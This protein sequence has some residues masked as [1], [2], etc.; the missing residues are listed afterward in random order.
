[1]I[2][3]NQAQRG[4]TL[5]ELLFVLVI[6]ATV[7]A[8]GVSSWA[9]LADKNRNLG[10]KDGFVKVLV[11]ARSY[12]LANMANVDLCGESGG[13]GEG[14]LVRDVKKNA[15]LYRET[16]YKEVHPVGP[17]QSRLNSGCVR[18]LSNGSIADVPAPQG[19]FYLSGFYGGKSE[20]EALWRVSF[21]PTGWFCEE[22]D[23]TKAQC[24]KDQ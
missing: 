14:Y 19:G 17:W 2:R 18:F 4:V 23:P 7:I 3:I 20:S 22:K 8:W 21:K 15:V 12:A 13:W 1:M 6:A 16:S 11:Y 5:V 24:A 10:G 9:T